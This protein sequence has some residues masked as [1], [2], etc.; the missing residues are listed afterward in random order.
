MCQTEGMGENITTTVAVCVTWQCVS[1]GG[2]RTSTTITRGCRYHIVGLSAASYSGCQSS[3]WAMLTLRGSRSMVISRLEGA[4]SVT[5]RSSASLW[6]PCTPTSVVQLGL[7]SHKYSRLVRT[8][9]SVSDRAT[10]TD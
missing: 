8:P 3:S 10:P 6:A 7:R 4:V 2:G 5:C 9:V 1:K